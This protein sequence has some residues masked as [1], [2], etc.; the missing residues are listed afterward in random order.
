MLFDEIAGDEADFHFED[1]VAID[2]DRFRA[3]RAIA[4]GYFRRNG[5]TVGDDGINDAVADVELSL[6]HI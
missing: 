3:L 1:V 5:L 2:D 4:A 6:I